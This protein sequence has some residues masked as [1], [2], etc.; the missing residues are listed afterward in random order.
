MLLT[1]PFASLPKKKKKN[2]EFAINLFKINFSEKI[3]K[4]LY[5]IFLQTFQVR[6]KEVQE[7]HFGSS[8]LS[9]I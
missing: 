1:L 4:L 6:E 8:R 5:N 7:K 2:P 9:S 3:S